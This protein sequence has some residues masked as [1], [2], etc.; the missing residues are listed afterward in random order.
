LKGAATVVA[1]P[2]G[3]CVVNPTGGPALG[4]GGSGDVLTGVVAALLAQGL[5]AD[6]AAAL[7]AY[8]HG[9][10]ADSGRPEIGDAGLLAGDLVR[11]LA[12]TAEA[13]RRRGRERDERG[14]RLALG[15]PEP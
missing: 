2:D 4:T 14:E 9:A 15:F 8:W 12:P 6:E 7:A 11:A 10:A 5:P 1:R 3:D 13:L